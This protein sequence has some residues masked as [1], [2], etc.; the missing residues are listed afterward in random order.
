MRGVPFVFSRTVKPTSPRAGS[1]GIVDRASPA[2]R[3]S[4]RPTD[5]SSRSGADTRARSRPAGRTTP[6]NAPEASVRIWVTAPF[7]ANPGVGN[8]VD[9]RPAARAVRVHLAAGRVVAG[10]HADARDQDARL[11][12][13]RVGGVDVAGD[14]AGERTRAATANSGDDERRRRRARRAA[15]DVDAPDVGDASRR[16]HRA[17]RQRRP[18][19]SRACSMTPK[20]S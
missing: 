2:G 12:V 1:G 4:R 20:R 17:E 19:P 18:S 9:A 10:A 6:A 16:R 14:R 11:D 7:G 15:A 8:R 13:G 5:T 3:P